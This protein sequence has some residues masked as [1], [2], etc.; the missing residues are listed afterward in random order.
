MSLFVVIPIVTYILDGVTK[1]S[2]R[3]EKNHICRVPE[4]NYSDTARG[5]IESIEVVLKFLLN[6]SVVLL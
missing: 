2:I 1:L 4:N 5:V 3:Q 6:I